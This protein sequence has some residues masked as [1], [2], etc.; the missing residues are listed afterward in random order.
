MRKRLLAALLGAAG[1]TVSA[2]PPIIETG[3]LDPAR[4]FPSFRIALL[5]GP[6]VT[7]RF[8]KTRGTAL[9][10][11]KRKTGSVEVTIEATSLSTG[12][13]KLDELLTSEKFFNAQQYPQITFRSTGFS[14]A[15]HRLDKVAGKLTMRGVTKPLTLDVRN[16]ACEEHPVKK[17]ASCSIK[18]DG[19]IKRADWGIGAWAPMVGNE[20]ELLIEAEAAVQ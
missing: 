17:T 6:V 10:D 1:F 11:L 16:L 13:D 7:G 2:T 14:F 9:L 3:E 19:R 4:T 20:V 5:G 12:I 18:L 8:D 15:G